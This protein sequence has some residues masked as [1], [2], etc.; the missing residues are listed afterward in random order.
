M[1][2]RRWAFLAALACACAPKTAYQ[3]PMP[4][5]GATCYAVAYTADSL[6]PV[7]PHFL[8]LDPGVDSAAAFWPPTPRDTMG[9]WRMFYHGYWKRPGATDSLSIIFSNG[10]TSVVLQAHDRDGTSL[11]GSATWFSDVVDTL[12]PHSALQADR[13]DCANLSRRPA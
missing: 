5:E 10:F 1:L 12:P 9:V 8:I 13:T 2:R 7:L 4:A 3:L 11:S 6:A